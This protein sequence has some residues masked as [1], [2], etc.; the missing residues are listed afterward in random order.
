MRKIY[1]HQ[2]LERV[3]HF[4]SILESHG[5]L[6]LLKNEA[7]CQADGI[8]AGSDPCPELWVMDDDHYEQALEILRPHYEAGLPGPENEG[9]EG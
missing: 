2:R 1:E 9:D 7:T 8:F 3:G 5:I 6:T 4:Q